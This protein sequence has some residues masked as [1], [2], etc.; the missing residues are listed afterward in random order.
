MMDDKD[1]YWLAGLLEGEGSFLA[2]VPS[3][4]R[5]PI[6]QVSMTDEDVIARVAAL[7]G[8]AAYRARSDSRSAER[9]WKTPYA[10]QLRGS[11]AV[12]LMRLLRPLMGLRRQ[13]Q[14][15]RALSGYVAPKPL[16]IAEDKARDLAR[17]YW[18]GNRRPTALGREYGIS[19]N[20][21]IYYINKFQPE[22]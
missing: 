2:P 14:I 13:A 10:V 22:T 1:L 18:E 19:R 9:G 17:R 3:S 15:D 7:W 4:P 8:K 12:H 21:A 11:K 6:I 5:L 16:L 20:L